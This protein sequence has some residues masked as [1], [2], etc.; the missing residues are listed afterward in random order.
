MVKTRQTNQVAGA[1]TD[2]LDHYEM[3]LA[4]AKI[5]SF[6]W[7]VYCDW[8]IEIAKPRLNSGD[9]EQ[10]DTA[11]R[12]LVYVLDK[13][14]KLL[15]PFMP[16]ITEELYQALPGSAETIMTQA[17]PTFDAAHNWAAEEEAFEKVMDYI[18]ANQIIKYFEENPKTN[19][20]QMTL[21]V[22]FNFFSNLMLAYY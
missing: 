15:H 10:A 11:R 21:S 12:V 7:D 13:A 17:W 2:N 20:L 16:F 1:M 22:L 5:N 8:F 18:K 19:P 6:I 14:L 9:A 3:G 4:A